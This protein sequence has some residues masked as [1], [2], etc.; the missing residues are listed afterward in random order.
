MRWS[1]I[2]RLARACSGLMYRSVPRMSPVIVRLASLC[3]RARPKSVTQRSPRGSISRLDGLTSRCSD[4]LRVRVLQRLGRLDA[5]PGRVAEEARG[6]ASS[7][8]TSPRGLASAWAERQQATPMKEG[9]LAGRRQGRARSRR[10]PPRPARSPA[11]TPCRS[12]DPGPSA[13]GASS[14]RSSSM[15]R[16]RVSPSM[17]CMA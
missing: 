1:M 6:S 14:C 9:R 10:S 15:T 13:S 16:A 3:S 17:N 11:R 8:P 12:A 5:E 4:A 7:C 2:T